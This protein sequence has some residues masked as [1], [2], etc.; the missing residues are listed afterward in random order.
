[1]P[2]EG[3]IG[4]TIADKRNGTPLGFAHFKI[5]PNFLI[6]TDKTEQIFLTCYFDVYLYL[7]ENSG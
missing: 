6:K 4:C 3:I 5:G 1:M 7:V 2:G